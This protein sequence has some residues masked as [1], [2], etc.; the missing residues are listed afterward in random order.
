MPRFKEI[1]PRAVGA[2]V[3]SHGFTDH[4]YPDAWTAG[5]HFLRRCLNI[6]RVFIAIPTLTYADVYQ[7]T[8]TE[9][10]RQIS[11]MFMAQSGTCFVSRFWHLEFGGDI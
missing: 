7:F 10:K 3:L 11:V 6:F 8:C 4:A 2:S 1:F 9:A 5:Q